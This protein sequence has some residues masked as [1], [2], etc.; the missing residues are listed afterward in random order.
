MTNTK[1]SGRLHRSASSRHPSRRD[2]LI[3]LGLFLVPAVVL[4]ALTLA[5][6]HDLLSATTVTILVSLGLGLPVLWLTWAMYRDSRRS[7]TSASRL[8]LADATDQLALA[9][10]DQWEAEAAVRRLNDPYPLPITWIPNT[11]LSDSW[12]SLV[13]LASSG[14]GWPS[15]ADAGTWAIDADGLVGG[16]ND[17]ANTLTRVPTGRI[18]VLGEPGAGKTMLMVRLVLD[19][20]AQRTPGSAVPVLTSIASWNPLEQTLKDWLIARLS[21]DH[22]G[23]TAAGSPGREERTLAEELLT[24]GLVIPILD[25]LDEMPD[26]ERRIAIVRINDSLRPGERLVLTCRIRQYQ[27]AIRSPEGAEVRLRGAAVVQLCP[28]DAVAVSSYLRRDAGGPAA[29]AR[30]ANVLTRLGTRSPIGLALTTPLMVGLARTIYNPRPGEQLEELRAPNELC[31]SGLTDRTA[32]ETHLFQAFIPAAYR[33][34]RRW[35]ARRA[36]PRLLF[37]AGHLEHKIGG[38]DL[39]W[40]QLPLDVPV[41]VLVIVPGIATGIMIGIGIMLG[42]AETLKFDLIG[43]FIGGLGIGLFAWYAAISQRGEIPSRALRWNFFIYDGVLAMI[44]AVIVGF[45][46][47]HPR[48]LATGLVAAAL[49]GPATLFAFGLE[50]AAVDLTVASSPLTVLARDRR[51]AITIW[52]AFGIVFGLIGGVIVFVFRVRAG[53][54]AGVDAG[55]T[56]LL[57]I[58]PAIALIAPLNDARWPFYVIA[59]GWLTILG[60]LPWSLIHFLADAHERG[61]LRQVGAVYQFRHIELQKYLARRP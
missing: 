16:D 2:G 53:L 21:L 25:G 48:G 55:L 42:F 54:V 20:L 57:L 11:S 22:P 1:R 47:G 46:L 8:S 58:I 50:G 18:V 12:D 52:L 13:R 51:S 43:G 35:T 34:A 59:R 27:D 61:V 56:Y 4:L 24:N 39:A 33:S 41:C 3:A 44:A 36:E 9:V 29:E 30:W 26:E 6:R 37:L 15:P 23:L 19:L 32:V 28:L 31:D 17:L 5:G 45:A 38:P 60:R 7:G 10:R 49:A 14:A 40:W